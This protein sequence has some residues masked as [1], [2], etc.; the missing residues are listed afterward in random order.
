[1]A[2]YLIVAVEVSDAEAYRAYS[3]EV[4]AT[5]APFGGRF[6]VRGGAF[7]VI[8]GSWD[9]G[10]IVVIEFPS[11]DEAKAWHASEAYQA[12]LP[13]REANARTDFMLVVDGVDAEA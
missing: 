13:I 3:A 1:M 12:I 2:A 8:E 11:A 5:L 9:A 10:R 4:P 6:V 7:E